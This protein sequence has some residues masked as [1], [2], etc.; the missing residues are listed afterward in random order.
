MAADLRRGPGGNDVVMMARHCRNGVSSLADTIPPTPTDTATGGSTA[1]ARQAAPDTINLRANVTLTAVNNTTNGPNGLPVVTSAITIEGNGNTISR[2]AARPTF[3]SWPWLRRRPDPEQR[4]VQR[5][6]RQWEFF[7][8]PGGAILNGGTLT[9]QNSTLSGNSAQ[10]RRRQRAHNRRHADGAEQYPLRQLGPPAAAAAPSPRHGDGAE[11][12]PLWERDQRGGGIGNYI[13]ARST[14]SNST[15][16]G[17]SRP[18]Q[19]RRHHDNN[20]TSTVTGHQN[21]TFSGNS[22][23]FEAAASTTT[24]A[25][26]RGW[27]QQHPLRQLGLS[28]RRHLQLRQA[29]GSEQTDTATRPSTAAASTVAEY[30]STGAVDEQHRGG[31]NWGCNYGGSV[32]FTSGGYNIE[33]AT[34]CRFARPGDLQNDRTPQRWP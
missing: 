17:N 31:A 32:T 25:P 10:L 34:T 30:S 8:S 18:Q 26:R 2:Q 4:H 27:R 11:Q 12:H 9:V 6:G 7:Q 33:S 16:S 13:G 28:R 20:G 1:T 19:R 24:T 5:R 22:W 14:V 29:D 21:S 23:P 3:A 15:F